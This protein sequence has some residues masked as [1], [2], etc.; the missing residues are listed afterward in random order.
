MVADGWPYV[1]ANVQEP[2]F[3][4]A[5]MLAKTNPSRPTVSV[6]NFISE[7]RDLPG[8]LR[9]DGLRL[10]SSNGRINRTSQRIASAYLAG[11]FGWGPLISDLLKMIDFSSEVEKTLKKLQKTYRVQGLNSKFDFGTNSGSVTTPWSTDYSDYGS[12]TWLQSVQVWGSVR[13]KADSDLPLSPEGQLRLAQQ[14]TYGLSL[15]PKQL[16]DAIPWSWFIDWFTNIG[17]LLQAT[18][19]AWG[20]SPTEVMAHKRYKSVV[21]HDPGVLR[22]HSNKGSTR[23]SSGGTGSSSR[24][25]YYRRFA[26]PATLEAS[27]PILSQ[28]QVQTATALITQRIRRR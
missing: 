8:M 5:A 6:P 17:D 28:G 22:C 24:T 23:I 27:V 3:S 18:Q 25:T 26:P 9:G 20:I 10:F 4:T 21:S 14:I 15:T 13:W 11:S 1:S 2:S 16:W 12:Q 19:N 7:L